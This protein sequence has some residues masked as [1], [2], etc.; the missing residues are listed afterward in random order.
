VKYASLWSSAEPTFYLVQDQASRFG[1]GP[2]LVVVLATDVSDPSALIPAI[3]AE[4]RRMDPQLPFTVEPVTAVVASTLTRH[5]LGTTLM[6]LFGAMALLLAAIG[7]YGM[8]A[9]ASAERHSEVATRMALGA[10][11]SNIFWLLS[12]QGLVVAAAGGV[13]GLASAYAA[14]QLV[15]NWLYAV[16]PSDP[17][18]LTMTLALV[19][20]VTL[21]ATLI[22][23]LRAARVDPALSLRFE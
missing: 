22:P 14:G 23:V 9:Y 20:S 18:I 1:G 7:L 12:R 4:V 13:I 11:R 17:F 10:T 16:K 6:V 15:S 3:R 19:L 5:K 2:R 21:V 8:I